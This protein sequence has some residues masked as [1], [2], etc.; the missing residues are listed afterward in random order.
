[1]IIIED[2]EE[3]RVI[4]EEVAFEVGLVIVLDKMIVG[5]EIDKIKDF[6]DSLDQE[7]EE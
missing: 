5:I 3:V 4:L 6:G 1:M 7:K 2:M